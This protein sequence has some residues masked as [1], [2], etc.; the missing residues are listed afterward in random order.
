MTGCLMILL[1]GS[2]LQGTNCNKFQ[3]KLPQT[4]Q[5]MTGSCVT[6]PCSF[7]VEQTFEQ[8]LHDTC[9]AI[10]CSPKN[11]PQLSDSSPKTGNLTMKNCTT[12]FNN[13]QTLHTK[14]YHFRIDC[15]NDLKYSF[16][17]PSV[18]I[19]VTDHFPSPTLTPSTLKIKEGESVSLMCSAPAP[20]L[21]H[22][23]NLTWTPTLGNIQETLHENLDKTKFK[24]S[25]MN[26]IASHLHHEQNISCTA[27]Y[28]KQDGSPD[29]AFTTSLIPD[30]LFCPKN[31]TVSVSPLGLVLENSNV[32]LTCNSDANPAE[33]NYTWHGV[34]EGQEIVIGIGK[35][36]NITVSGNRKS[37]VCMAENDVGEQR[38]SITHIDVLYSP[39]NV[40]VSV[41]P[42]GPIQENSN[43]ILTC[44]SDA[45]PAEQN[46]TW[47]GADGGQE[48]VIGTGKIL[49]IILSTNQKSFFCKAGNDLGEQYSNITHID[50]LYSPKNVTVSVSP[51]GPILD[52][53]NVSLTCNSDA[54]PAEQN[55]TWYEVK[56]AQEIVTG[57]GK[58]LN[59]K[60][61]TDRETFFCKAQ[62]DLGEERSNLRHIDVLFPSQILFSS[63]CMKTS[64]QVS[65]SCETAGNPSPTTHW[66]L[67][68]KPVI[69]SSQ[70]VITHDFVNSSYMRSIITV[71][72]PQDRDLSTLQCFSS[73]SL[74]SARKE[75]CVSCLENSREN[76]SQIWMP[77]FIATVVVFLLIVCTLLLVIGFQKTHYKPKS[78]T[79]ASGQH[80]AKEQTTADNREPSTGTDLSSNHPEKM[81]KS[82]A[83]KSEDVAYARSKW[84]KN[85]KAKEED[86]YVNLE[87]SDGSCLNEKKCENGEEHCVSSEKEVGSLHTEDKT[88]K[89]RK[90]S[91]V[92]YAQVKF[93]TKTPESQ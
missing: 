80:G 78:V 51:A 5:V 54:N 31:V 74:G 50:V 24:T 38:S 4:V 36:L 69:Q 19:E 35:I 63:K 86:I 83:D 40:S 53:S 92:V 41:N 81:T 73:N 43:V 18:K 85:N 68:G 21:P 87:L 33:Q 55:Y 89:I 12:T 65:C 88:K 30:V 57:S 84:R 34:D 90:E 44:N 16:I 28:K 76:E 23:P 52:N 71:D 91:E 45:N 15:K 27:A 58:I 61:T 59:F 39:K 47:Y 32:T 66:Y 1:I 48:I 8:Y 93:W 70:M 26:F 56:A 17:P 62:N 64:N 13:M 10:W 42:S 2:L 60:T 77:L 37:F 3:T 22:P 6:V 72:E 46:Y 11:V 82:S 14:T 7:D 75:F 79:A 29:A 20:C 67:N 25:V 49:Y 9:E